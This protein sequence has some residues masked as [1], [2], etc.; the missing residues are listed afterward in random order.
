[1]PFKLQ[2]AVQKRVLSTSNQLMGTDFLSLGDFLPAGNYYADALELF[3]GISHAFQF[4][5]ADGSSPPVPDDNPLSVSPDTV[6]RLIKWYLAM[7]DGPPG[8]PG[9]ALLAMSISAQGPQTETPFSSVLPADSLALPSTAMTASGPVTVTAKDVI[10]STGE[11]FSHWLTN[12]FGS[13]ENKNAG[14]KVLEL[15]QGSGG[16]A[17][18][19]FGTQKF[20]FDL[21]RLVTGKPPMEELSQTGTAAAQAR[22]WTFVNGELLNLRWQVTQMKK[23]IAAMKRR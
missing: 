3:Q 10:G 6:S 22:A 15:P 9:V 8:P 19:F 23:A 18:A 12:A 5:T 21:P 17:V 14:D 2:P 16:Y 20:D 7:G 11:P 13:V 1:M 4:W